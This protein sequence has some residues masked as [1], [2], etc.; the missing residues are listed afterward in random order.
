MPQNNTEFWGLSKMPDTVW[1]IVLGCD[2]NKGGI[3]ITGKRIAKI[4]NEQ[5]K[6][7]KKRGINE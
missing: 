6:G 5:T 2:I 4:M 1:Q 3:Q 7:D